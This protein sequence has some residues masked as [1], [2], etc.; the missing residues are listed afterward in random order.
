[1]KD[2]SHK[3]DSD[4]MQGVLAIAK[5][6]KIDVEEKLV[7]PQIAWQMSNVN[8]I[9]FSVLG[10]LGNFSLV[11]G[12]AKSRK[13]FFINI[14]VSTAVS[15]GLILERFKSDLPLNQNEV[16]YFDTEQG[17]F[18]VQLALQRICRQIN[19]K[20]PTNLHVYSLRSKT[21]SER[22]KIIVTLK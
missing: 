9:G 5:S 10:T 18:H 13:S 15:N 11:I 14:A 7:P 1:M 19:I 6:L 17:K 12:K 21:P 20:E 8:S 16:L 3:L 22:L 2:K 4:K